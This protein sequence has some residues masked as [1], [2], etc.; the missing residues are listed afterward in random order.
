[1]SC[2]L[3]RS[4]AWDQVCPMPFSIQGKFSSQCSP[5][6][7]HPPHHIEILAHTHHLLARQ[8]NRKSSKASLRKMTLFWCRLHNHTQPVPSRALRSLGEAADIGTP[9]SPALI[10]S[11]RS[12]TNGHRGFIRCP[13]ATP[14]RHQEAIPSPADRCLQALPAG[15][16]SPNQGVQLEYS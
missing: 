2:L 5:A 8:H 1:M 11:A 10:I 3:I 13:D 14:P 16:P 7:Q 15:R 6:S 12:P 4:K 9:H